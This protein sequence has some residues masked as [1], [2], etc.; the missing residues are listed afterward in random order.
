MFLEAVQV[1][2][3]VFRSFVQFDTQGIETKNGREDWD[4]LR[5]IAH[6]ILGLYTCRKISTIVLFYIA[7]E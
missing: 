7:A 4:G 5:S 2:R 1:L 3:P 6:S